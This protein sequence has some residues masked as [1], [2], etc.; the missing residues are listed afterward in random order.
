MH[1]PS[2][3]ELPVYAGAPPGSSW[4]LW[5]D[6]DVFGCLNLLTH[7][8]VQAAMASADEGKVFKLNHEL[9]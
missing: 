5:G 7:E 9:E 8:R 2:F 3:D 6:D 1:L 4:G